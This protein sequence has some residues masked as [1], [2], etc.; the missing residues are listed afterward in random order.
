MKISL[1][2]FFTIA[3]TLA[4]STAMAAT[5]NQAIEHFNRNTGE[6][7]WD[8]DGEIRIRYIPICK[9][10]EGSR[11]SLDELIA[12][13]DYFSILDYAHPTEVDC[14]KIGLR[15][16]YIL[17]EDEMFPANYQKSIT[18]NDEKIEYYTHGLWSIRGNSDSSN[19]QH[20]Y[21]AMQSKAPVVA[22]IYSGYYFKSLR[23]SFFTQDPPEL[24]LVLN[25]SN[26]GEAD[27]LSKNIA[28]IQ[29]SKE[30]SKIYRKYW[31]IGLLNGTL[32]FCSLFGFYFI[33]RRTMRALAVASSQSR[34][35]K[36]A[37]LG[38]IKKIKP[39]K[40]AIIKTDN[41]KTYSVADELLKWTNLKQAGIVSEEEFQEARNK[42]MG[43]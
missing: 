3:L 24:E 39:T 16:A 20:M 11:S 28:M 36:S 14:S 17:R 42:I 26:L 40:S 1:P 30:N 25:T 35:L 23:E 22:A 18:I 19:Y 6:L 4:C 41:L 8:L 43:K 9:V 34:P 12:E 5:Q 38:I 32:L 2:L 37:A 33:I 13:L 29:S 31:I 27:E 10:K 21:S 15:A 7:Y